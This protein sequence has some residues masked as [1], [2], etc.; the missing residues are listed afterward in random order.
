VID[1]DPLIRAQLKVFIEGSEG[2]GSVAMAASGAEALAMLQRTTVDLLLLDVALPDMCGYELLA[3]LDPRPEVIMLSVDGSRAAEAFD[4][5]AVDFLLKPISL[6]RF[7]RAIGR[8]RARAGGR[9]AV[10]RPT[11]EELELKCGRAMQRVRLAD[12]RVVQAMGNFVKLHLSEGHLVANMTMMQI[13]AA[14][15]RARF[16][17]VHRSYLVAMEAMEAIGADGIEIKGQRVPV[18]A[19]YR[20]HVKAWLERTR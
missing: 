7:Q 20:P 4:A 9:Q 8:F 16:L 5:G 1:D 6:E 3:R 19:R 17:R 13:E 11:P 18:G 14:L 12:I 10:P 15:P 2:P